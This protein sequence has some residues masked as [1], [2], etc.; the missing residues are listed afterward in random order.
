M[1]D[2]PCLLSDALDLFKKKKEEKK[3]INIILNQG[4]FCR[5]HFEPGINF[6]KFNV[7][8]TT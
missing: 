4:L 2:I 5:V 6:H 7:V 1:S 3:N 8:K